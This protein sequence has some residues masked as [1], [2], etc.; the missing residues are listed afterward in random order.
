MTPTHIILHHSLTKDS[1]TVSWGAIKRY[2]MEE[3]D[4]PWRNIGY[5][6]GIERVGNDYQVLVGRMMNE[7][8]AHCPE[9]G[10]N[11]ISLGIC[12]IGDYDAEEPP[13]EMWLL[14]QEL[15]RSLM[16]VFKIPKANILGHY[17]LAPYKS[18]PGVRFDIERFK[19][20]L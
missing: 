10:M 5:H 17:E 18:C 16:D 2:H 11:R 8:G 19:E 6:F 13:H 20:E 12:F 15:V 4:P 1:E 3:K 9:R 14:G 7:S